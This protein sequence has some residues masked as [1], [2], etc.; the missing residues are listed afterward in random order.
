[1]IGSILLTVALAMSIFSMV[2]YFYTYRGAKNTINLARISYHAMVML[3]IVASTVLLYA[4]LTH[5]YQYKYVYSY[6]SSDLPLGYLIATFWAGQ[7]GS[8]MLWLLLTAM[9]G[10][11]LQSYASKHDDLEPRLMMI[12]TLATSF[13][14]VMVSPL[15]KS[16]FAYLW[17]EPVFIDIKNISQSVLSIPALQ[18]FFFSDQSNGQNFLKVSTDLLPVL[19][20][21]GLSLDQVVIQGKGL[22]PLLQNF[23]MQIH[24]PILFIG[25]AMGTV[26]FAFAMAALIKNDYREWVRQSFPWIL[27]GAG[28]LGLGIMLGGYWAY[29]VLGWGGYWA[30]DP[31]ENSSLV[32]WLVSV[33]AIHTM[34]VQRKDQG[35]DPNRV[36]RYAVTNLILCMSVYILVLYSTFLTRSGVLG[37]ASVHSFVDPGMVVYLFLITL[38]GSFAALGAG[39]IVY[40]W[41]TLS[42]ANNAATSEEDL[43][44][45][46]LSLFTAAVTLGASALIVFTGTSAPI[47]G[48]SVDIVFYDD[49]HIPLA[50]IIGLL[51][52]LSLVLK[53]KVTKG[54][55]IFKKM[56]G[57]LLATVLLTAIVVIA[58][59]VRD[60]MMILMTFSAAFSLFIN[61]EIAFKIFRGNAKM[62]GAYV[63]HIGIALF[64]LGVV[65]SAGHSI[66]KDV[67]LRKGETVEVFGHKLTF[68]G[69]SPIENNKKFAFHVDVD[70]GSSKYVINPVM[71]IS[72]F[73]NGLMREPDILTGLTRDLYISPLGYEEGGDH[74]DGNDI[75]LKVNE[76]TRVAGL[77]IKY[78]EF[79]KPDMASMMNNGDFQMGAKLSVDRDG[80]ISTLDVVMQ[81]VNGEISYSS[82]PV[83][84][85]DISIRL[86][87]IDPSNKNADLVVVGGADDGHNHASG[88]VLTVT[89]S[90]KPYVN[91]VWLGVLVMT[92][93]FFF[94]MYRRLHEV[95]SDE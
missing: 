2:M 54:E 90:I 20:S 18:G 69:Y 68:T 44:S 87:K 92:F 64:I 85:T 55:E 43:L 38:I 36:G 28:V 59:G 70:K 67:D 14:L 91:L 40:R 9:I 81:R 65:G 61:A 51:N 57:S 73:N 77:K 10:V 11:F 74:A 72:E 88:E 4:L 93:G 84:G 17:A 33:A 76:E 19:S 30:W 62:A 8:F 32:P 15:L 7:E 26:P 86:K 35:K 39:M 82:L 48:Q 63:A 24:P 37:D 80:V 83:P 22:N 45:R 49:L 56:R 16:P 1:M 6:S 46:E 41:K 79:I 25:F 34:V 58:G 53:W 42:A 66:E 52:G 31:V 71:Y 23:W 94:S 21:L 12:Y 50:I 75:M 29:G 13:L 5:Q 3:V 47:F 78:V 60:I 95:K 27:G 89:A